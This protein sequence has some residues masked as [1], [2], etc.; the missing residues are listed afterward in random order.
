[1]WRDQIRAIALIA[2][3]FVFIVRTTP[4]RSQEQNP[5]Q[6][7]NIEKLEIVIKGLE[8]A[9]NTTNPHLLKLSDSDIES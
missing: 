2:I 3:V 1:M 5:I 8:D 9:Q 7:P 6:Q 4:V